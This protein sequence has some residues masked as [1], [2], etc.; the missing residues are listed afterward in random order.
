MQTEFPRGDACQHAQNI[1]REQP[2]SKHSFLS[3]HPMISHILK[4]NRLCGDIS[5]H[6][7]SV[8]HGDQ[9]TNS[10][11]FQTQLLLRH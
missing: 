1:K 4:S 5:L 9:T 3:C 2:H 8:S 6:N 7:V 10:L 11:I